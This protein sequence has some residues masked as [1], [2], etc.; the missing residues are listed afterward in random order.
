MARSFTRADL[1]LAREPVFSQNLRRPI[2]QASGCSR[3]SGSHKQNTQCSTR[4][5][6]RS[7]TGDEAVYTYSGQIR[8]RDEENWEDRGGRGW[9]LERDCGG[10]VSNTSDRLLYAALVNASDTHLPEAKGSY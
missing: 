4:R 9:L 3:W 1:K 10:A 7:E 5:P 8:V 6:R 2:Y